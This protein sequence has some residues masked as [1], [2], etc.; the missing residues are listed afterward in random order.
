MA[1]LLPELQPGERYPNQDLGHL[2]AERIENYHKNL[3]S[4]ALPDEAGAAES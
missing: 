1:R 2:F 4:V 3:S